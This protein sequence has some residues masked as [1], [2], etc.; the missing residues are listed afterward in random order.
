MC[1]IEYSGEFARM[2][3]LDRVNAQLEEAEV[4]H[5]EIE[6]PFRQP[7]EKVVSEL[8]QRLRALDEGVVSISGFGNAFDDS[9][10]LR[11][12][13]GH[14]NFQR[15]RFADNSLRQIWWMPRPFAEAFMRFAPD[16]HSWFIVRLSIEEQVA[17]TERFI[18]L[19]ERE[20]QRLANVES[21]RQRAS[22]QLDRFRNA[23]SRTPASERSR[24][25]GIL[26]LLEIGMDA[27]KALGEQGLI[28]EQRQTLKE[29]ARCLEIGNDLSSIEFAQAV[30]ALLEENERSASNHALFFNNLADLLERQGDFTAARKLYER[31]LG[32]QEKFFGPEHPNTAADLNNLAHLLENQGDFSTAR[33]LYER[34]LA[35]QKKVVGSEHPNTAAALNNLAHLMQSQG[36]FGG[37]RQLYEQSLAIREKAM[38][39][40][41][42]NTA[43][44][45]N[46]LANLLQSQGDFAGARQL[47]ERALAIREKVLGPE[48]PDTANSLNNIATLLQS[49]GDPLAALPLHERALAI[50]EK[51][52]GREHPDTANSLNNL[53]DLLQSQGEFAAARRLYERALAT[54]EKILGPEHPHTATVL[55]N[56][57]D[58]L[59]IQGQLTAAAPLYERALAIREKVL[60]PEHPDT[61]YSM[62][63]FGI[64]LTHL[65]N[66][67]AAIS[68]LSRAVEIFQNKLAPSD[69]DLILAIEALKEAEG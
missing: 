27:A 62:A 69:P 8:I 2:A 33:K 11:E 58:L 46:N 42:P 36:D 29:I 26:T 17:P 28:A 23:V 49:Q 48:H 25:E 51:V 63:S 68:L 18:P 19:P 54:Q 34:A 40:E 13:I 35:I 5:H 55:N 22:A 41:H 64:L 60:G 30:L 67:E 4:P 38:G 47:H 20:N 50:R 61:G 16:T 43:T 32:I 39:P 31:A 21:V 66:R 24:G 3:A 1:R 45:L 9:V 12:A 15:E 6:L 59:H 14:L 7:P 65:G 44:V 10:S 52:L 57:A 53:A 37:A 56:L